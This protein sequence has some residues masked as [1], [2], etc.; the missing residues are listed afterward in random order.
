ML[1]SARFASW[2]LAS[3][4]QILAAAA[5]CRAE[6][7]S[8]L[9]NAVLHLFATASVLIS[10]MLAAVSTPMHASNIML[11]ILLLLLQAVLHFL[12]SWR[13]GH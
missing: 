9:T 11:P 6:T 5:E 4:P 3:S 2:L 1:C 8:L 13:S 10:L 12:V 7:T